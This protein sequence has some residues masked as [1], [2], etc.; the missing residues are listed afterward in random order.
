MANKQTIVRQGREVGIVKNI[1]K[2]F[3]FNAPESH[4]NRANGNGS[5]RSNYEFTILT[6]LGEKEQDFLDFSWFDSSQLIKQILFFFFII[7][8]NYCLQ[9]NIWHM[10]S[11]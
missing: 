6:Q 4:P 3:K 8:L 9:R 10:G 7:M 1:D 2:T 11:L 5:D